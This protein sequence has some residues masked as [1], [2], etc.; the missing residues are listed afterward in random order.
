[1]QVGH[2][3]VLIPALFDLLTCCQQLRSAIILRAATT[4]LFERN[5]DFQ[6]GSAAMDPAARGVASPSVMV[7]P[8]SSCN[9]TVN[10]AQSRF[11]RHPSV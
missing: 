8:V 1:M 10:L 2:D 9:S 11:I 5:T 3:P 6:S 7:G 4:Y